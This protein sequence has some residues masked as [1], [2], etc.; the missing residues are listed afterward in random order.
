MAKASN[1]NQIFRVTKQNRNWKVIFLLACINDTVKLNLHLSCL[2]AFFFWLWWNHHAMKGY[3]HYI[4][5]VLTLEIMKGDK[6]DVVEEKNQKVMRLYWIFY[7]ASALWRDLGVSVRC[8]SLKRPLHTT[9]SLWEVRD[10]YKTLLYFLLTER[11]LTKRLSQ[12]RLTY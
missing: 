8:I 12:K 6:A 10:L 7:P 2:W 9:V 5:C 11:R 3:L 1:I 4:A